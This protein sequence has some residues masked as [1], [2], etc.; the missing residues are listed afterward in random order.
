MHTFP[1]ILLPGLGMGE[2][3]IVFVIILILFGPGKL[4]NV[5]KAM[6]DGVRQFR[7]AAREL[8]TGGNSE[9]KPE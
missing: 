2:L 9:T 7:N 1:L 4:P 6:G 8:T 3:G 5:M